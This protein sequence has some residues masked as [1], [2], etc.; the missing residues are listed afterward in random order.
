MPNLY[1]A[2][3]LYT[4]INKLGEMDMDDLG[5]EAQRKTFVYHYANIAMWKLVR[6]AHR[7]DYSDVVELTGDGYAEFTKSGQGISN[8]YEPMSIIMPNGQP[9][10]KR[11]AEEAPVGWWRESETQEIHVRGF[12][13]TTSQKLV[14]GDYKLKFIRYPNRITIDSDPVDFPPSGYDALIKEVLSLIKY[15][16]NSFADAEYLDAK[17]KQGYNNLT[18]AAIASKGTGTSGTTIGLNDA[19]VA[20]G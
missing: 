14:T 17:A 11:T 18:N 13:L 9:M 2:G 3:E 20:K 6:L 16:K 19:T 10:A 12:S 4:I 1:N 8:L 15:S 7:V 5:E